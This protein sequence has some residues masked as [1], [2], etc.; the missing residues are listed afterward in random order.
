[1]P[2]SIGHS[3][4]QTRGK[5]E[6]PTASQVLSKVYKQMLR[7]QRIHKAIAVHVEKTSRQDDDNWRMV[8]L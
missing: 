8:V 5:P 2:K 3:S 6:A 7:E 1:M 4:P